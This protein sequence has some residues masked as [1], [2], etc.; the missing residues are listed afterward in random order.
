MKIF[1]DDSMKIFPIGTSRLHEPL[2]LLPKNEI[3]FS[4]IGY[5]HSSSQIVDWIKILRDEKS[6]D[7]S[8]CKFFFRKDQTPPNPFDITIWNEQYL[9]V[10]NRI[11]KL[12]FE[13]DTY[14]IEISTIKSW[15]FENIHIQSNPN[16]F[17]NMSYGDAW[18]Q[19]YYDV[20]HPD[21]NVKVY[22]DDMFIL[23][24]LKYINDYLKVSG[25]VALL[26]GHL[27]DPDNPNSV[28]KNLNQLLLNSI[29]QIDNPS[30]FF[31]DTNHLVKKYGFRIL[32]NGIVDIH[33]IP[34]DALKIQVEEMKQMLLEKKAIS[35]KNIQLSE[36]MSGESNDSDTF[37]LSKAIDFFKRGDYQTAYMYYQKAA[38][39]Y[40]EA[41][42]EYNLMVCKKNIKKQSINSIKDAKNQKT[43]ATMWL[44]L[45]ENC[46][47]DNILSRHGLKSF[48][49]PYSHGRSNIDYALFLEANAYNTFLDKT[50]LI[51]DTL[52]GKKV[53]RSKIPD[54]CDP[55]FD[56]SHMKGFEFTHHD[57][58]SSV[59]ARQ[60]MERKVSR[61]ID[62]RH[63]NNIT[64]LYHYRLN[65]SMDLNSV[66]KK[67]TKFLSY[68]SSDAYK[69][70]F[71]VFF[72]QIISD[73]GERKITYQKVNDNIHSF[74]IHSEHIWG[75]HDENIFWARND[76]DLISDMLNYIQE[77]INA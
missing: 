10:L 22:D 66:Y 76:D 28:R 42:V 52:G 59:D 54:Q 3:V 5:F 55:I 68:Y 63:K 56:L 7:E 25:K 9:A 51:Y 2:S 11:K 75:G 46:L 58:I 37:V 27:I 4:G 14:I 70:N 15:C 32:E 40:G 12:F 20:Y 49:T 31:F 30:I 65:K 60:S 77:K 73:I 45:G 29:A 64:F 71:I 67:A 61:L 21:M 1:K 18:K 44:S 43:Y 50:N 16:Y 26:L 13:A 24:N 62:I 35:I 47:T 69:C 53:V 33:H 41:I 19:G 57:I 36:N 39:L 74:T 8:L 17:Y 72:Q 38:S 48:S 34:W 23:D 6:I